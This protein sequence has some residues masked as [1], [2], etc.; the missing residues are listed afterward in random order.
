MSRIDVLLV[1]EPDEA[2]RRLSARARRIV[3][4]PARS[5]SPALIGEL[6]GI[7]PGLVGVV[8]NSPLSVE[9]ARDVHDAGFPTVLY[10]DGPITP[11]AGVAVEPAT[12]PGLPMDVV[13]SAIEL[14]GNTPLVR[15][16][17]IGRDLSCHL[18]AKLEYLNPGGSVKDR[19]ALAMI[20]AAER[21]GLL[22]RGGT[23]V[24]PTSGNTGVGP[25]DG[26]RPARLPL[27]LHH[28]G[29]DRPTRSGSSCG[30]SAPRSW[31]ARR[32]CHP[33]TPSP[34]TR[35]PTGSPRRRPAPSSPTST[36]TRPTRL[37][38]SGPRD[39][40]SGARPP[41]GSRTS[42][43]ASGPAGRSAASGATSRHRT[44]TVQVIAADPEGSIY[45]GGGG[46]PYL[47]EGIGEDFWPTT[48]DPD[49]VDR[50]VAVSRSRLL[51]DRTPGDEARRG[52][53]SV[54]R[55]VPRCGRRSRWA[56]T[57]GPDDVVVVLVPDSG[58]GYL[59]K[60]YDDALDG[61]PRVRSG[62]RSDR[63]RRS[64][65]PREPAARRSCTST[66]RRRSGRPSRS[67][68]STASPRCPWSRRSRPLA[69]RRGGRVGDRPAAARADPAPSRRSST[70][71]S[72]RSWSRP[73]PRW[74]RARAIDRRGRTPAG[75]PR[76]CWC[77][78]GAI[79][80]GSSPVGPAGL[81]GA[82]LDDGRGG[83]R[84]GAS[85]RSPSTPVRA[86]D[87]STGAVVTPIYQ[88]STTFR[89]SEVGVHRGYEY[90]RSANPTR[91]ALES[92]LAAARGCGTRARLR[93][94]ARRRGRGPAAARPGRPRPDRQRRLRGDLPAPLP[95]PRTGRRAL[96]P[97]ALSDR[98]AGA[99]PRGG[100]RLAWSGWRPRPTPPAHRRH[101]RP[102]G[103]RPRAQRHRGGGQHLRHPL[104]PAA[105]VAW[106]RRGRPLDDQVPG[107]PQRRGRAASSP[108]PTTTARR[109]SRRS[110]RTPSAPC[111]GPSTASSCCGA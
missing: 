54:A 94:R 107:R 69:A 7:I 46:R 71:R 14:V 86:P 34:T 96:T 81:P 76:R 58:R 16:D 28:A 92:C 12:D 13:D 98:D 75:R 100:R 55:P 52:S 93:E 10:T 20:D 8:G 9:I 63:W 73:C 48:Y 90:S 23:I 80:S 51:P 42:S 2:P 97:V 72:A 49:V 87:E 25:G 57:L 18:L 11:P 102:G 66:P 74:V 29:Q 41:A 4:V 103:D 27:H 83:Q 43:P 22:G 47:V 39:R 67:W 88:T 36:A 106:R 1:V 110:S 59:S 78:T 91:T 31:S 65:P 33:S 24:E 3:R 101:R 53:S 56:T 62:R 104:P 89:Q 32:R 21:E 61:R 99:A 105:P 64:W 109:A 40:R 45:S 68:R 15:L 82:W 77:S 79:R 38:T 37:P 44:R 85:R 111:P 5:T 35:W 70:S 26:G 84:A 50:V 95:G 30:P 60:L 108:R 17:R 19:P 6:R